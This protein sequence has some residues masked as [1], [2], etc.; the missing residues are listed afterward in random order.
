MDGLRDKGAAP[1]LE[2]LISDC[3]TSP[4]QHAEDAASIYTPPAPPP[5]SRQNVSTT[6][7][8]G[9]LPWRRLSRAVAKA[10]CWHHITEKTER[11]RGGRKGGE[12]NRGGGG[13]R[14]LREG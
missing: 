14:G 13:D 12:M 6:T 5:A 10:P 2:N 9:V 11:G 3:L 7:D 1:R 8:R 4:L